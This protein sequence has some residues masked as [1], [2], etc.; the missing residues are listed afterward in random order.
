MFFEK[1]FERRV[2]GVK[3]VFSKN[4]DFSLWGNHATTR[5]H[6]S[7]Y[8]FFRVLAHSAPTETKSS[9]YMN[10]NN[11]K[12]CCMYRVFHFIP[13]HFRGLLWH[14][15]SNKK[16][17]PWSIW[18]QRLL[19]LIKCMGQKKIRVFWSQLDLR[20]FD[21]LL[22]L[23]RA[24]YLRICHN[25]S[26]LA[27]F[28]HKIRNPDFPLIWKNSRFRILWSLKKLRPISASQDVKMSSV[29][30]YKVRFSHNQSSKSLNSKWDKNILIFFNPILW[31][32]VIFEVI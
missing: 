2:S 31:N 12:L 11:Q 7:N 8:T 25:T 1:S 16:K 30:L 13:R 22:W 15:L 18:L 10:S 6:I 20:D 17:F 3:N 23:N 28:D 4:V 29:L 24:L 5:T 9:W 26:W 27:E 14:E 19:C 21:L 32:W